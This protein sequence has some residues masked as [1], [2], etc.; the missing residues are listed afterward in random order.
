MDRF[1]IDPAESGHRSTASFNAE[2]REGLNVFVLDKKGMRQ[3][4]GP[5]HR[6]LSTPSV[7]TN[8]LHEFLLN[9]L[10]PHCLI[11]K[12]LKIQRLPC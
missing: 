3:H 12:A 5:D 8:F 9:P 2:R 1:V 11:S 10:L 6:A 7:E 4:L